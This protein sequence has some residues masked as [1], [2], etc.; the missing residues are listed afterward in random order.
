MFNVRAAMKDYLEQIRPW[1]EPT[2]YT[3]QFE[4]KEN[5]AKWTDPSF[6]IFPIPTRPM[7]GF[8]EKWLLGKEHTKRLCTVII[9]AQRF[10]YM[11]D[12]LNSIPVKDKK[13]RLAAT[14]EAHMVL[15]NAVSKGLHSAWWDSLYFITSR[16]EC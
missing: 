7:P 9:L 12:R 14:K 3:H 15:G 4:G 11:L 2:R 1:A 13:A 6:V 10:N 5:I 8:I 16:Q